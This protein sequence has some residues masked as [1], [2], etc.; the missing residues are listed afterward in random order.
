[1]FSTEEYLSD[2]Q[3]YEATWAL[4]DQYPYELCQN[5]PAHQ[6]QAVVNAK[7][8]IIGR[9]YATGI[10]R[11]IRADGKQGGALSQV[12]DHFLDHTSE[13]ESIFGV[14]AS[15]KEPPPVCDFDEDH[16]FFMC[17]LPVH[18]HA[19]MPEGLA[20]Q[21][22]RDD[23]ARVKQ[24]PESR[25]ELGPESILNRVL[26]L[27]KG[28][29]RSKSELASALGHKSISSKLNLRIRVMLAADLIAM[30]IPEKPNSR[31]QK[32]QL[33]TKGRTLLGKTGE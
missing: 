28:G 27:L 18:P 8:W 15:I 25:P 20:E 9:T 21:V 2:V 11:K 17:R 12:A 19:T 6:D 30:T 26:V 24:G 23:A 32:Y 14:L 33:T 29:P 4:T 22:T 7:L 10:E 3:D 5:H 13:L 1:M 31:L 16:S